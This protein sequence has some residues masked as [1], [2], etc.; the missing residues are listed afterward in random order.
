[1]ACPRVE[2]SE[3]EPL[4][5]AVSIDVVLHKQIVVAVTYFLG[6][7]QIARLKPTLKQQGHV[8][9]ALQLV[10]K[11][12]LRDLGFHPQGGSRCG[13]GRFISKQFS[14]LDETFDIQIVMVLECLPLVNLIIII[15][16]GGVSDKH[17]ACDGRSRFIYFGIFFFNYNFFK[18]FGR[19]THAKARYLGFYFRWLLRLQ[20][21]SPFL[22]S[23]LYSVVPLPEFG[24]RL[25]DCYELSELGE[26]YVC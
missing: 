8:L 6:K 11:V 17:N 23:H 9:C 1:V 18:F 26:C 13:G 19:L 4:G 12:L 15:E 21:E 10:N 16:H 22:H 5:V 2:H 3:I 20:Q 7:K 25:G 14:L 24:N